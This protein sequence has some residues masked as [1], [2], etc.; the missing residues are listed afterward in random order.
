MNK[1]FLGLLIIFTLGACASMGGAGGA[2]SLDEAVRGS[3]IQISTE[4]YGKTV[5]VINFNSPTSQFSEYIID[6]LSTALANTRMLTVVERRMLDLVRNELQFNLSGEVSDES[7]QAIGK[8]LGA[9]TVI[10]GNLVDVGNAWRFRLR[11]INVE[12]ATVESAPAYD[13]GKQ[14]TRAAHLLAT[15]IRAVEGN[16]TPTVVDPNVI[17]TH[18][19]R[20]ENFISQNLWSSAIQEYSEIIKLN[21]NDSIAFVNLGAVN[22]ANGNFIGAINDLT[23]AIRLN[24]NSAVAY[25]NR[26]IAYFNTH[27]YDRAIADFSEAI[28]LNPN[29]TFAYIWRG[30]VHQE[31]G[32]RARA[33]ADFARTR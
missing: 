11:A 22:A 24:P 18:F 6:E 7:A 5:A 25:N 28:R 14:D 30:L 32:D 4:L 31:R 10:I 26:G 13:I 2:V 16:P 15:G 9:E 19:S 21:P 8:M 20:G 27:D 12:S 33:E 29:Y 17:Q 1:L 3:A 23:E